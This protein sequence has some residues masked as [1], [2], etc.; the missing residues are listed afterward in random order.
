MYPGYLPGMELSWN[1]HGVVYSVNSLFPTHFLKGGIGTTWAARDMLKSQS[2]ADAIARASPVGVS[3]AMSYNLGSTVE[4]RLLEV[5]V[6]TGGGANV[7]THEI[8]QGEAYFHGNEFVVA[9]IPPQ[10]PDKSTAARTA[11]WKALQPI[12]S[13][14]GIRGFLSDEH[15]AWPVYRN[16][17]APD[18]CY[19]EVTGV[20]DLRART[21]SVWSN[22]P[23]TAG[24]P[25]KVFQLA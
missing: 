20:F 13:I 10:L 21:L 8:A 12:N 3:T 11:R 5:E 7:A 9:P 23:S 15:G 2:I 18:D 1:A 19:T 14:A 24:P 16:H 6:G 22:T 4:K 25:E 17:I